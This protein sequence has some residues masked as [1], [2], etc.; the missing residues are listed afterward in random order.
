MDNRSNEFLVQELNKA[1]E[2]LTKDQGELI[3]EL[4][5]YEG[6]IASNDKYEFEY[7]L[8]KVNKELE[9]KKNDLEQYN[10][11]SKK[12]LSL[13]KELETIKETEKNLKR[14]KE[15][16]EDE[17]AKLQGRLEL[18]DGKYVKTKE[19]ESYELDLAKIEESLLK[20]SI[21]EVRNIKETELQEGRIDYLLT[22]YNI[23]EKYANKSED[24]VEKENQEPEEKIENEEEQKIIKEQE[25]IRKPKMQETAK[26]NS[27]LSAGN[28][29][30]ESTRV[31]SQAKSKEKDS[32]QIKT[33]IQI[34]NVLCSVS[35]GKILYTIMGLDDKGD[36]IEVEKSIEPKR[37]SRE[38]KEYLEGVLDKDSIKNVDINLLNILRE[39]NNLKDTMASEEYLKFVDKMS[40][41]GDKDKKDINLTYDLRDLKDVDITIIQKWNL[42]RVARNNLNKK[43]AEYIK[44]Q[45]AFRTF[46]DKFKQKL[47]TT[48]SPETKKEEH[49][50]REDEI[51]NTYKDLRDE[52]GF[53]F[54]RFCADMN[55]TED[56][57]NVLESF[58][59]VNSSRKN[60]YR[61]LKSNQEYISTEK[62][63]NEKAHDE[64]E[65]T[66]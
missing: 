19:Q 60:F 5:K 51:Y 20:N 54:D 49:Y 29:K 18:V 45:S 62:E 35:Q 36:K 66:R 9:E 31:N 15:Q 47:L 27:S 8:S 22:K 2:Q 40:H 28:L 17:M 4:K 56:E 57:K 14:A 43:M 61:D 6:K 37:M 11:S 59:K 26:D 25:E 7:D 41:E 42:R 16:C 64:H 63:S 3:N 46:I 10:K 24:N 50:S 39:D 55:L 52:E 32:D 12:I 44:P 48:G 33:Q 34:T 38:D 58:E 53:D 21:L 30:S 65:E 23:L 13:K 1:I